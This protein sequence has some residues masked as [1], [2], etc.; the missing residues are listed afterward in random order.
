MRFKLQRQASTPELNKLISK[1]LKR[2]EV[3]IPKASSKILKEIAEVCRTIEEKGLPDHLVCKKLPKSL[4]HG[5]FLHPKAKPI[6]K[7]SVIAPY[8][9]K[10][11]LE[12]QN[13]PD[14][15]DYAFAPLAEILLTKEEQALFDPSRRHHPRR[16]YVLNLDAQK[17]GNFTRFINHSDKPNIEAEFLQIPKNSYGLSPAPLEVIYMA[18]KRILPGEQLLISY[19]DGDEKS[20]WGVMGITPYPLTPKTFRLSS[21]LKVI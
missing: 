12:S 8:S 9:G 14:D 20:Y 6:E 7:G 18:K 17:I 2:Q 10:L 11:S 3:L 15:S 5:I 13:D 19:E 21:S 16:L 4:G 1:E